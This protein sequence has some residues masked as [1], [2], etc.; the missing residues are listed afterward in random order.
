MLSARKLH[1][2][3]GLK[4]S[5]LDLRRA[6]LDFHVVRYAAVAG[7]SA[8]MTGF[9]YVAIIKIKIPEYMRPEEVVF[10]WQVFGFYSATAL[11]LCFALYN[12]VVASFLIVNALGLMLRGPP[13]A[14][15]I[16]VGILTLYWP[17]TKAA[18]VASLGSLM[19]IVLCIIWMKL[20]AS[21]WRPWT[22]VFV[23]LLVMG[24][25]YAAVHRIRR[26]HR[27]L[28]L[29]QEHLI[30]GDLTVEQNTNG[31]HHKVDLLSEQDAQIPLAR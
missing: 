15:Q 11:T 6:E 20:D 16:A 17:S 4:V 29:R 25:F 19:S 13:N 24:I 22:S 23:S 14:A 31:H 28:G 26:L 9:S 5:G 18:L 21:E 12:L 27:E 8:M 30:K 7:I 10:A 2:V 1:L 3:A